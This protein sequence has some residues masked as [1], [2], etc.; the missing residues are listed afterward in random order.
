MNGHQGNPNPDLTMRR[1][2]KQ[3]FSHFLCA[4]YRATREVR[5]DLT[6]F[7]SHAWLSS[8]L[9]VPLDA[10]AVVMGPPEVHGTGMIRFGR[11]ALLYPG[12][13][14]ETNEGGS[15]E[16]GNGVV[17]SR[18]V[19]IV[20]RARITIGHGT[21]IGEYSSLRD[22]NHARLPD[23]PLR[24]SGF[25]A[26]P[27]CIGNEVWIGRGVAVLGG[28][29]IGDR[30]TIGANAVVTHDV[31]AG[32]TVGGVPARELGVGKGAGVGRK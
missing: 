8:K 10:S 21:M 24:E 16:I 27:I 18:G 20:A 1:K 19:H 7:R 22:A 14:L 5:E 23:L 32:A 3:L 12:V 2:L 9:A 29:T 17:M 15:I 4:V 30:A 26:R 6:R 31:P 11:D 13:Y 28:V 25:L